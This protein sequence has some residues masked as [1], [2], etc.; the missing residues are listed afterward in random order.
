M[1]ICTRCEIDKEDFDFEP[2]TGNTNDL[3]KW[4]RDCRREAQ[5][6]HYAKQ[7]TVAGSQFSRALGINQA[8][9]SNR[10]NRVAEFGEAVV[11]ALDSAIPDFE[12]RVCAAEYAHDIA[13]DR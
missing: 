5:R 4:C 7:H 13:D 10:Q 11:E 12:A 8:R 3:H 6:T 9:I 1:T 2:A